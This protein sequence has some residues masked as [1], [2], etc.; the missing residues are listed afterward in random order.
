MSRRGVMALSVVVAGTS[1]VGARAAST[2]IPAHPPLQ[3]F[4]P[5]PFPALKFMDQTGRPL[6]LASFHGRFVLLSIW[7]TWYV[8]CQKDMITLDRLQAERGGPHF[9]IVPVSIDTGGLAPVQDFYARF[10]I[11]H[12]G[13]YL[14]PNGSAMQ[15]L[16]LQ[17]IPAA[18][19][20][21]PAG[22]AIGLKSG[23]ATWDSSRMV[24]FLTHVMSSKSPT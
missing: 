20:I 13:I 12:L 6:S 24:K 22:E 11:Q 23:V 19:L 3:S 14:D 17:T 4:A 9:V 10:K 15:T 16:N 1:I 2:A 8:P 18:F 5:K 21:D 7:A